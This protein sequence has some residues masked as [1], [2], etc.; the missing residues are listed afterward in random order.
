MRSFQ[1]VFLSSFHS[2]CNNSLIL[3]SA[4]YVDRFE[5]LCL[6]FPPVSVFQQPY[7]TKHFRAPLFVMFLI[8]I[9]LRCFSVISSSLLFTQVSMHVWYSVCV[10]IE[11]EGC[12][13]VISLSVSSEANQQQLSWMRSALMIESDKSRHW[14][15][16]VLLGWTENTW[17]GKRESLTDLC[18]GRIRLFMWIYLQQNVTERNWTGFNYMPILKV[19]RWMMDV[20]NYL[21]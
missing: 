16:C 12:N 21:W 13:N 10:G 4:T 8:F 17:G 11:E 7:L 2:W 15:N 14:Q 9:T 3:P 18:F 19:V 20:L 6:H 5:L 1:S